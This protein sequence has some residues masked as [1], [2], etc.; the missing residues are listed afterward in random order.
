LCEVWT[1]R[2]LSV[3]PGRQSLVLPELFALVFELFT[4]AEAVLTALLFSTADLF[5]SDLKF[6]VI[7]HDVFSISV[8]VTCERLVM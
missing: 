6:D 2:N 7:K 8:R 4:L 5:H 1:A 3:V